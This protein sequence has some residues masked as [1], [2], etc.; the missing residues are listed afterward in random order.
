MP[1]LAIDLILD[2]RGPANRSMLR[3]FFSGMLDLTRK[4]AIKRKRFSEVRIALVLT[5]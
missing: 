5:G 2:D 1:L 3:A 4:G